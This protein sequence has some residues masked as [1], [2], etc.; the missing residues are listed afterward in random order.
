MLVKMTNIFTFIT[1]EAYSELVKWKEYRIHS[2]ENIDNY[3]WVMRNIWNTKK[4]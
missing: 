4:G 3:S 2:G 1:S